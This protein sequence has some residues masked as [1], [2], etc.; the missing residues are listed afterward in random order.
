MSSSR[1]RMC[2]FAVEGLRSWDTTWHHQFQSSFFV[3]CPFCALSWNRAQGKVPPDGSVKNGKF[4]VS[5]QVQKENL[6]EI[7]KENLGKWAAGSRDCWSQAT[8]WP[9]RVHS[10]GDKQGESTSQSIF[11]STLAEQSRMNNTEG[12]NC[13]FPPY[14]S[15]TWWMRGIR[16]KEGEY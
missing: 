3:L 15:S 16:H 13:I 5:E 10:V 11:W 12:L 7:H 9:N 4:T 2:F 14:V 1:V 6:N 8:T